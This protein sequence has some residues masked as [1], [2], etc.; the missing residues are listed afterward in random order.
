M[1]YN[2]HTCKFK[3]IEKEDK[4]L[5]DRRYFENIISEIDINRTQLNCPCHSDY[6]IEET[7]YDMDNIYLHEADD[8]CEICHRQLINKDMWRY[9]KVKTDN[10]EQK[11]IKVCKL[12]ERKGFPRKYVKG[13]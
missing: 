9:I 12:C 2:C 8:V 4:I 1:V 3:N 13:A 7:R 5:C 11:K 6:P 10:E